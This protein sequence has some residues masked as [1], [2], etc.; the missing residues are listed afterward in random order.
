ME[1][2]KPHLTLPQQVE[3][4]A[5][6]GLEIPDRDRA[7]RFLETVGYYRASA[8]A[9]PFRELLR[10]GE[11]RETSVQFRGSAFIAGAQFAW[12]ED[13]WHFDRELRLLVMDAIETVEIALRSKVGYHLGLRH[14]FGH[15]SAGYLD[16]ERTSLADADEP[17]RSI[18]DVW[19]ERYLRHQQRA[20]GSEDF[21]K[22]Y[23]EKYDSRLPIWVATEIMEFGQLVRLLGFMTDGDQSQVSAELAG[24]SGAVFVRWMKVANYLRNESAHHARLWNRSLTYKLGRVPGNAPLLAHL[25]DDPNRKSRVYGMCA[26]LAQLTSEIRPEDRWSARLVA[27]LDTFPSEPPVS[28]E[29]HMGFPAGWQQLPLWT[30]ASGRTPR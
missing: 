27:L 20:A 17:D 23:V 29:T 1:Y 21:I 8:Y 30:V 19:R 10:E 6:R 7:A 9:Y 18:F 2:D 16:S 22:H 26:I 13:I 15:L 25:N 4:L 5:S 12:V 3:K 28:P 24:V 14:T 11:P